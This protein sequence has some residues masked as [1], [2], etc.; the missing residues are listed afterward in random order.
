MTKKNID[1]ERVKKQRES[2]TKL[3]ESFFSWLK[4][5]GFLWNIVIS[6]PFWDIWWKYYYFDEIYQIIEKYCNVVQM[7]PNNIEFT[8]T[9]VWSLLYKRDNQIVWREIFKLTIKG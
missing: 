5:Q 8:S 9:K 2:L 1:I 6:F 4:T 3:Y 7:L